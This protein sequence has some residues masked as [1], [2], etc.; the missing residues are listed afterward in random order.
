[1]YELLSV[2]IGKYSGIHS[3]CVLCARFSSFLVVCF[4][5][6]ILALSQSMLGVF[7]QLIQSL[8]CGFQSF[9]L[10]QK[11][12]HL[13]EPFEF[14]WHPETFGRHFEYNQSSWAKSWWRPLQLGIAQV[15]REVCG[16]K[17]CRRLFYYLLDRP[18]YASM[19]WLS[20][21]EESF[22]HTAVKLEIGTF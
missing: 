13:S 16:T 4:L 22:A 18:I 21:V 11:L 20:V 14:D 12:M 17:R 3:E 8:A 15:L 2:S 10:A 7:L 6:A 19:R 5:F 9:L 1:M